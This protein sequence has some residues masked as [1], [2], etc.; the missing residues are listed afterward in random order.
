M[1]VLITAR[2]RRT[3][4]PARRSDDVASGGKSLL[5]LRTSPDP[6]GVRG[7]CPCESP[8]NSWAV[9]PVARG[10]MTCLD[11][12]PPIRIL[13]NARTDLDMDDP[14]TR[15]NPRGERAAFV[16]GILRVLSVARRRLALEFLVGAGGQTHL[17]EL[18]HHVAVAEDGSR[19][20]SVDPRRGLCVEFHHVHLPLMDDA[21]LLQYDPERRVIDPPASTPWSWNGETWWP[22]GVPRP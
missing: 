5:T 7:T 4:A 11:R 10:D 9:G 18:V 19:Q 15:S 22:D 2:H 17:E 14:G 3:Q 20:S 13:T 1:R 21:G 12:Q 6:G 16:D 8:S